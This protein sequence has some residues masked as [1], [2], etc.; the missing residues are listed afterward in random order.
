MPVDLDNDFRV[1]NQ[2][3][4]DA[5]ELTGGAALAAFLYRLLR[6]GGRPARYVV[7]A[8]VDGAG[9]SVRGITHVG[10]TRLPV[11]DL[12][13][14]L[15]YTKQL[16][17]ANFYFF[18]RV[19]DKVVEAICAVFSVAEAI[20]TTTISVRVIDDSEVHV[21]SPDNTLATQLEK[22]VGKCETRVGRLRALEYP[23]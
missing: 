15:R 17:W 3:I 23:S 10:C 2:T 7:L 16:D 19:D 1:W 11:S 21:F 14:R 4:I 8:G 22:L 20:A 5:P 9:D 13:T 6:L 18:S 12:L